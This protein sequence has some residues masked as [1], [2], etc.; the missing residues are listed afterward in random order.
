MMIMMPVKIFKKIKKSGK[1]LK[2]ITILK[3]MPLIKISCNTKNITD[4]SSLWD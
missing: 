4:R 3:I 2:K 1:F